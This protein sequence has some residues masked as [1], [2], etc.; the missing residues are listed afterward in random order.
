VPR[1]FR[2]A[3]GTLEEIELVLVF[4]EPGDP[5]SGETHRGISSTYKYSTSTVEI[6]TD[7]FHRNVTAVRTLNVPNAICG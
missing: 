1:G 2:G 4:A 5:H 7:Q 3:S 6:G